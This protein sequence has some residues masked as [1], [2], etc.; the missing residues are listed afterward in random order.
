MENLGSADKRRPNTHR[1]G[2]YSQ[3]SGRHGQG[4]AGGSGGRVPTHVPS[5][6]VNM[7]LL[8]TR[9][10]GHHHHGQEPR[11]SGMNS[12]V[13]DARR[14][15]AGQRRSEKGTQKLTSKSESNRRAPKSEAAPGN[16]ESNRGPRLATRHRVWNVG[17]QFHWL[18]TRQVVRLLLGQ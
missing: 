6:C 14:C 4:V 17:P 15:P 7:I 11:G 1:P 10:G 3:R 8:H 9:R 5:A 13:T 12:R 2:K 16:N 18:E